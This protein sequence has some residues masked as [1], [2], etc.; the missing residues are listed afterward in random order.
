[1]LLCLSMCICVCALILLLDNINKTECDNLLVFLGILYTKYY[2][3][4]LMFHL[5][6]FIDCYKCL[7]FLNLMAATRF[8]QVGTGRQMTGKLTETYTVNHSVFIYIFHRA[9]TSLELEL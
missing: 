5:T 2:T 6:N 3:V 4:Y 1:M 8:K 7:H 9:P